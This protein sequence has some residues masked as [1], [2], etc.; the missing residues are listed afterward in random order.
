MAHM[1]P[2][3]IKKDPSPLSLDPFFIFS[4]P[5]VHIFL[6]HPFIMYSEDFAM[7]EQQRLQHGGQGPQLSTGRPEAMG[8][9]SIQSQLN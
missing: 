3:E 5:T 1:A 9:G 4:L 6:I 2:E 8:I 7:W